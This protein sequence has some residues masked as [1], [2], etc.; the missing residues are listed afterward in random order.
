MILIISL[1][2]KLGNITLNLL[3]WQDEN[4]G[5]GWN[6]LN[7]ALKLVAFGSIGAIRQGVGGGFC[8]EIGMRCDMTA[9]YG[10]TCLVA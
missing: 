7:A 8:P 2:D 5:I 9:I 4:N 10:P 3:K 6:G 1:D